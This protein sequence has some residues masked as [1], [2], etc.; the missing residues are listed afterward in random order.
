M[1]KQ[2]S[3]YKYVKILILFLLLLILA[4]PVFNAVN[5]IVIALSV[6]FVIFEYKKINFV[7]LPKT[8]IISMALFICLILVASF[9]INDKESINDAFKFLYWMLPFFIVFYNIQLCKNDKIVLYSFAVALFVSSIAVICQYHFLDKLRPG[10]LYFQPN[11]FASMMDVLLPFATMFI[12]KNANEC[13]NKILIIISF[14][15]VFL[16]FYSLFLSGSRGGI[17]GILMGLLLCLICYLFRKFKLSHFIIVLLSILILFA[18]GMFTAYNS[19]PDLFQRSYDN[20]RLLLIESSYNMWNDH[21]LFGVGLDNWDEEYN[22]KYKLPQAKEKLDMP[23]NILA[24]FFSTT[25]LIGGL[26]YII[27]IVGIFSFLVKHLHN[28]QNKQMI[29]I[30]LAMLWALFAINIH[31]MVDVGLNNKFVMRL[32]SGTLGLAAAYLCL[33][34]QKGDYEN[35]KNKC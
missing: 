11:H 33:E 3:I 14:I 23:H 35:D 25:G 2:L 8:I 15:L 10:G 28:C 30:I 27:F 12:L 5:S 29:F 17:I 1:F 9:A 16:G 20:E 26:G 34:K 18:G 31:G 24:F 22:S 13:K 7:I 4:T 6:L 32:F 19:M 21:K